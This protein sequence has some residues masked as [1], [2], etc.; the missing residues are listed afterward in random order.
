MK[1][2]KLLLI[3]LIFGLFFFTG[4]G[5]EDNEKKGDTPKKESAV[6]ST[7]GLSVDGIYQDESYENEKLSLIYVFYTVDKVEKNATLFS[8]SLKMKINDTNEYKATVSSNNVPMFTNYAYS[9]FGKKVYVGD[10][11]K[12]C[13]T[14][15]VAKGDLE[16]GRNIVFSHSEIEGFKDLKL[17]TDDIKKKANLDEISKDLDESV[18]TTKKTEEDNMMKAVDAATLNMFKKSVN[19]YY[20]E[21]YSNVGTK[22]SKQKLEFDAPNKFVI[23]TSMGLSNSGTYDVKNGYVVLNYKT[24]MSVKIK[25]KFENNDVSLL[26]AESVFSTYTDYDPLKK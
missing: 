13:S 8:S 9:D 4:C 15:E 19:G 1:K 23:S 21:F 7:K 10:T 20:F 3:I 11:F 17:K 16:A 26:N 5:K 24:G 25:Y 14:I 6:L 2:N 18:Y 22:I 12:M